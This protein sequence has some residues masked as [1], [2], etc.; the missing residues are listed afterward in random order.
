[1]MRTKVLLLLAVCMAVVIGVEMPGSGVEEAQDR[2]TAS[3]ERSVLNEV[4][5]SITHPKK[6]FVEREKFTYDDTYGYTLWRPDSGKKDADGGSP[7]VRVALAYGMEPKEIE[8][9]VREKIAD[10]PDVPM[11]RERVYVGK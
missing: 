11:K 3:I 6:W 5:A 4:G 8:A 2:N 7:E 9:T 1:M 10:H